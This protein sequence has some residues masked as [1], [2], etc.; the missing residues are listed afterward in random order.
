MQTYE[1]WVLETNRIIDINER[2]DRIGEW[3]Y[4][5]KRNPNTVVFFHACPSSM[6]KNNG[7]QTLREDK[8]H[9]CGTPVPDGIKM[10]ALL[11]KL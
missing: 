2:W 7:V 4:P 1:T 6:G 3:A 5:N 11:G 10:I 8:C 9:T